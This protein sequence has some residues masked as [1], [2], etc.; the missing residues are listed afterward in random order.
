M[1]VLNLNFSSTGNTA[2]ELS[3]YQDNGVFTDPGF[4]A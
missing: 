1:N 2:E 3:L 4:V